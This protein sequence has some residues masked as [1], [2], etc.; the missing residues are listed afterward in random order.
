MIILPK[1]P[2]ILLFICMFCLK[3]CHYTQLGI[4]CLFIMAPCVTDSCCRYKEISRACW[5]S[6]GYKRVMHNDEFSVNKEMRRIINI[7]L[8]V[9]MAQFADV[10]Q[11]KYIWSSF[12]VEDQAIKRWRPIPQ[13]PLVSIPMFLPAIGTSFFL[14]SSGYKQGAAGT[15]SKRCVEKLKRMTKIRFG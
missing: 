3:L 10:I 9:A 15:W 11:G 1:S 14:C 5:Y 12:G 13:S 2:K 7:F 4:T 6:Y 8:F